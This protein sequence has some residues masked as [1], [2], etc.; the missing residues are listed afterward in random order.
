MRWLQPDYV[1][2]GTTS[3]GFHSFLIDTPRRRIVIDA[4]V[5]NAK[6]RV[7]QPIFNM[8]DT[9]YLENFRQ[10]WEPDEV[11]AVVCTHMHVDHV[12]WNTRLD[13]EQWVPTFANAMYHFVQTEYDHWKWFADNNQLGNPTVDAATVFGDSVQPIV[14]AGLAT[15]IEPDAMISPE[16]SV[17][18]SRGH[19]PGH[20]SVL[21][22]SK[23]ESAVI[24]GDLVHNPC[25]IGHPDWS[26]TYDS[27]PDAAAVTRRA[28][29]E[30]FADTPTIVLGTHFGTPTGCQ[31]RRDGSSYRLVPLR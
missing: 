12:G 16:V 1:R 23:A 24:T 9:A 5:G 19:T 29:L 4:A 13:G 10:V 21:I 27:D 6:P 22:Q 7:G 8:L 11:D 28:F 30:R 14:E 15:F 17:I 26:T 31:I 25:W 3:W 20:V 18:P 2:D